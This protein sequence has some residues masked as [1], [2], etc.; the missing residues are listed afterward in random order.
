MPPLPQHPILQKSFAL[1]DREM[2]DH[3][4]A[5][6]EYALLRRIIHSTADFE[7]AHLLHI[8]S[9]AIEQGITALQSGSPIVTDVGMVRQGCQGV[10]QRTFQNPLIAAVDLADTAAPGCTRTETGLLRAWER[11]PGGIFVIGNAPTALQALCD[12]VVTAQPPP[13]L[14]IGAPVG[15]VGVEAA[16]ASLAK[17]QL[18]HIRIEGRKGG[19]PVAAAIINALLIWAWEQQP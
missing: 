19:S 10:V 3:G 5:P 18:P 9:N 13:A 6:Q 17:S 12:H 15:F 4:F 7:F 8:S 11:Y 16:K 1:I 14:V 2:G